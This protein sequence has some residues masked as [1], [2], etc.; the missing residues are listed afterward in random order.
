MY[1][2]V[3]IISETS[4][5][6]QNTSQYFSEAFVDVSGSSVTVTEN[7]GVLPS[8][9]AQLNVY[10][11]GAVMVLN[12]DYTVAGSIINFVEALIEETISV[13]FLSDSATITTLVD[14]VVSLAD[15]KSHL[16][17]DYPDDDALIGMYI[18]AARQLC[19]KH[20]NRALVPKTIE[21]MIRCFPAVSGQ[22]QFREIKLSWGP[23][24][25][26]D[27]I[28]YWDAE[29]PSVQ[30]TIES[31]D[32][33]DNFIM[34]TGPMFPIVQP[35]STYTY[36]DTDARKYPV[37]VR[38]QA[39]YADTADIPQPIKQAMLLM[40]GEMYEDRENKVY[41][42]PTWANSLLSNYTI[43]HFA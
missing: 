20:M 27:S 39:G 33:T 16:K 24:I 4:A 31:T 3:K 13:T 1:Q 34:D 26:V 22:H 7:G 2:P 21:E 38:Y 6:S 17:V 19:E 11:N 42:F 9:L 29:T 5:I 25:Q 37:T 8:N 14:D 32:L 23:L 35:I 18:K 28:K 36:P 30:Q 15:A 41:K 12:E 43:P 40:I 10:R